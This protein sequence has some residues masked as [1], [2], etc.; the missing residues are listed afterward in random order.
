MC[1]G[2]ITHEQENV[3][4][5]VPS[6]SRIGSRGQGDQEG[7]TTPKSGGVPA[8]SVHR[9][10]LTA[11]ALLRKSLMPSASSIFPRAARRVT[12][13]VR[14]DQ[15]PLRRWSSTT[16]K[17]YEK[18]PDGRVPEKRKTRSRLLF[19]R[20]GFSQEWLACAN[21]G[22]RNTNRLRGQAWSCAAGEWHHCHP[23]HTAGVG[24]ADHGLD[25]VRP[26]PA[27]PARLALTPD[28]PR[29]LSGLLPFAAP[30]AAACCGRRP[31]ATASNLNQR[32]LHA[33]NRSPVRHAS[34]CCNP[35]RKRQGSRPVAGPESPRHH[36]LRMNP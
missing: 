36:I 28:G 15:R 14:V 27:S 24:E 7:N 16:Q 33:L 20:P 23:R 25:P 6:R 8:G 11:F 29:G 4:H 9:A 31:A 35:D 32:T 2:L 17:D 18:T 12:V 21:C 19:T 22:E 30:V 3:L 26:H 5:P 10:P 34:H 1:N 13:A